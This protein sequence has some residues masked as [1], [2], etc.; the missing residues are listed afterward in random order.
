[1]P[2][3]LL[4]IAPAPVWLALTAAALFGVQAV[5]ARQA[6]QTVD[7][8]TGSMVTILTSTLLFW[9]LAPL[10]FRAEFFSSAALWIFLINGLFHPFMSMTLSF[11][12][13]RRMGPTLSATISG[14]TPLFAT[15]GAVAFLGEGI[16]AAIVLGTSA[17][18]MGGVVL[19]MRGGGAARGWALW[20][21]VL[22]LGAAL[23]RAFNHVWGRFGLDTLPE[24]VFAATISF[25][26]SAAISLLAWVLRRKP[27]RRRLNRRG[28]FWGVCGGITVFFSIWA[29]YTALN[30]GTV[31]VV[32]PVVN[33]YPFFTLVIALLVRQE[34]LSVRILIGV[35]LVVGGVVLIGLR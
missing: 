34:R 10:Y 24:P 28:V 12:A 11:E 20:V 31:V 25:S 21:L 30:T 23:V 32:S 29:M 5:L 2:T 8:Q 15:I 16:T 6:V 4:S 19:S 18:V 26:S 7:A 1:M 13:N 27:G 14:S 33:T 3:A 9:A 22:P 35:L 17:I